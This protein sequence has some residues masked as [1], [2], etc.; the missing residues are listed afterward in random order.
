MTRDQPTPEELDDLTH[1][2]L[3]KVKCDQCGARPKNFTAL[4]QHLKDKHPGG[5][6]T[7]SG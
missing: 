5:G 4:V 2:M 6:D 7:K 1:A 3:G